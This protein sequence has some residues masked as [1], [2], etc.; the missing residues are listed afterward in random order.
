LSRRARAVLL[1]F[2]A[3]VRHIGRY[4][5][6]KQNPTPF[7]WTKEPAKIIKKALRRAR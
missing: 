1:M 5:H 4:E 3:L 2:T 6:W 7:I